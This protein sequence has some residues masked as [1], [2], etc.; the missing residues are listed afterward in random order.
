MDVDVFSAAFGLPPD[1][2]S[3]NLPGTAEY[4]YDEA[5]LFAANGS[6]ADL[7]TAAQL[8]EQAMTMQESLLPPWHPALAA[9]YEA[10]AK[11]LV[12]MDRKQR[13]EEMEAKAKQ[14]R[15]LSKEFD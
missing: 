14:A 11:L 12:R 2:D 1:I 10:Y 15:E 3:V 6:G 8:F 4:L 13:A 9:T 7:E 5:V